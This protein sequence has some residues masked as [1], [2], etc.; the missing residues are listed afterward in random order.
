MENINLQ[1][2]SLLEKHRL[3]KKFYEEELE[4][5]RAKEVSKYL[6][7]PFP[8]LYSEES[9]QN[10]I[11][12]RTWKPES[13]TCLYGE[14]GGFSRVAYY[15]LYFE[16]ELKRRFK[17]EFLSRLDGDYSYSDENYSRFRRWDYTRILREG[18]ISAVNVSDDRGYYED[19]EEGI[20]SALYHGDGDLL[21]H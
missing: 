10:I 17:D 9:L 16:Y 21:G 1:N 12:W 8:E 5:F 6:K 19:D 11:E 3:Y 18:T 15:Y 14:I 13:L 2:T 20:M 7:F 4:K